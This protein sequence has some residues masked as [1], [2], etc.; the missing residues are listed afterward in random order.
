MIKVEGMALELFEYKVKDLVA[1]RDP[2]GGIASLW[3]LYEY[4]MGRRTK[5]NKDEQRRFE[6]ATKTLKKIS[7]QPLKTE[8]KVASLD[9]L[10]LSGNATVMVASAGIKPLAARPQL[11]P[12]EKKEQQALKHLAQAVWWHEI[13][14]VVQRLAA[15]C[16]AER[17]R[18]TSRLLYALLRNFTLYAKEPTFSSDSNLAAFKVKVAIPEFSDPLVSLTDLDN[19]AALIHEII[20][21]ILQLKEEGSPYSSL[22]IAQNQSLDYVRRFG[23]AVAQDPYAGKFSSLPSKSAQSQQL[24]LALQALNNEPMRD[25]ERRLRR[26]ELEARI[27]QALAFEKSQKSLFDKDVKSFSQAVKRFFDQLTSYLPEHVGG[28]ASEP[29]LP[30]GVLFAENPALRLETVPSNSS[31][32]TLHLKGPMRFDFAGAKMGIMGSAGAWSLHAGSEGIP[33]ESKLSLNLGQKRILAFSEGNYVHL[34]LQDEQRSLAGLVAEALAVQVILSSSYQRQ[35]LDVLKT[36]TGISVGEPQEMA[37]QAI[38]RLQHMSDKAPDRSKALEGFLRGSARALQVSLPDELLATLV[39]RLN[40]A[41]NADPAELAG[42]LDQPQASMT[43]MYQLSDEPLS[44]NIEGNP[45]TIRYY[46]RRG[47]DVPDNVVVMLPGRPL[48]SFIEYLVQPLGNGSLVCVRA[49]S[50]L[51]VLFFPYPAEE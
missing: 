26:S 16:R 25:E 48:G 11:S 23:L 30:G 29:Q 49:K 40:V 34:R 35:L 20:D 51:A 19:I 18:M 47:H 43:V 44:L 45:L 15:S 36:A 5:L 50:D 39:K 37:R 7:E 33:L 17:E 12:A 4:L 22:K 27:A 41:M 2:V 8:V 14:R 3:L 24:R 13:E 28:H 9:E 1:K 21:I 6:E 32:L 31:S 46:R 42:I 38:H 10:E